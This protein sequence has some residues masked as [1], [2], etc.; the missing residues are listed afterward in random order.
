MTPFTLYLALK[1][2]IS[3][4]GCFGEAIKLTNW[5][6]F[7]KNVILWVLSVPVLVYGHYLRPVYGPKTGRWSIYWL[8]LFASLNVVY[9]FR[10]QP[11]IDFT[12]FRVGNDLKA[13]TRVSP[14]AAQDSF[15][16]RFIYEKNGIKKTF[17][18]DSLPKA[19]S[20]WR[21]VDRIQIL[22]RQGQQPAIESFN[23]LHPEWGDVTQQVLDDTS[24]VFLLVS[25]RLETA[26]RAHVE[27]VL[28][29][30]NYA[31]NRQYIF[32]GL[33][34]SSQEAID[35][36][37]YENDTAIPFCSV[38]DR[39]LLTMMRANP[40]LLLLKHGIILRKWAF[41]DI[42]D[43]SRFKAPLSELSIGHY[44]PPNDW[45]AAGLSLL[46]LVLPLLWFYLMHTGQLT[47]HLFKQSSTN[48]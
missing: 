35:E 45:R 47:H 10:H 40:G 4:C 31:R 46:A 5:Q 36:W 16:Y 32:Y 48:G 12:P 24:Y 37:R 26:D 2:P 33:T 44:R 23:L 41:R 22:I 3:D 7:I 42:P 20:G 15:D 43:F 1:N 38:D 29:A 6:T 17:K 19:A 11:L 14:V 8:L 30:Y 27:R 21:F 28:N 18:L 13:L 34:A 25:P 9:A 39:L